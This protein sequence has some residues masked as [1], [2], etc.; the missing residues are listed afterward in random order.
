LKV[1]HTLWHW[2][3]EDLP[4]FCLFTFDIEACN[5]LIFQNV[6]GVK[7]KFNDIKV[8][9]FLGENISDFATEAQRLIKSIQ[10]D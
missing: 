4:G 5:A 7:Q 6:D 9:T 10:S 3:L 1:S 8:K 2:D